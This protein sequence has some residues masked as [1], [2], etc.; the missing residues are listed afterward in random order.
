MPTISHFY[1]IYILLY[2]KEHNPPH[3]HVK[4][5]GFKASVNIRNGEIL[6]GNL[7]PKARSLTEE[8]RL[9]HKKE[10]LEAWNMMVKYEKVKKIPG[11]K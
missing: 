8:W 9:I 10:L 11:L 6:A 7:P 5:S 2:P 1:G 3:F 4:Y